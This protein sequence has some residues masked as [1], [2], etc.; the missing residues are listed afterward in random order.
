MNISPH[1]RSGKLWVN[2]S[3]PKNIIDEIKEKYATA[4]TLNPNIFDRKITEMYTSNENNDLMA[5]I[6]PLSLGLSSR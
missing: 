4:R 2:S 5:K 3:S 6:K 1:I